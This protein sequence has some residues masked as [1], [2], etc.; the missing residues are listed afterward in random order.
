[1]QVI[2]D[3]MTAIEVFEEHVLLLVVEYIFALVVENLDKHKE[4]QKWIK[5]RRR[6]SNLRFTKRWTLIG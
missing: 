1:M 2:L 6:G 5:F 3:M 4:H